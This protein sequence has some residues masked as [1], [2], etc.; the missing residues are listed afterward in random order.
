MCKLE[1]VYS[2]NVNILEGPVWDEKRQAIW[3]VAIEEGFVFC[4]SKEGYLIK[5]YNVGSQVG[6]IFLEDNY[7]IAAT[8]KGIFKVMIDTS[9]TTFIDNFL[10]N[11]N[12]RFN[13]GKKDC[14]GRYLLGTTGYKRY[15]PRQNFLY[16]WDGKT[17]KILL[18][19]TSISNGISFSLDYKYMYFVDTPSKSVNKYKYNKDTG[20]ISFLHEFVKIK[21]L[22]MPDGVCT[23]DDGNIWVALWNGFSVCKYDTITG[24]KVDEVVLPIKNVSSCCFAHN[25]LYI[26][27]AK[28]ELKVEPLASSLFKYTF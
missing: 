6:C 9:T 4:I 18:R 21:G 19:G 1:V 3:C 22:G 5:K 2:P 13:D 27:T 11:L 12:I 7:F 15:A 26:T 24:K 14:N 25:T 23:D 16:S 8:H 17:H 10:P 28:S 20:E